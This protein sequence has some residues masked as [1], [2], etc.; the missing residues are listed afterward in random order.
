MMA[1]RPLMTLRQRRSEVEPHHD[2]PETGPGHLLEPGVSEDAPAAHVQLAPG[3]LRTWFSDHRVALNRAG[4][5]LTRELHRDR[6][7]RTADAAMPELGAGDE[8][9]R[10]TDAVVVFGLAALLPRDPGAREVGEGGPR[11]HVAPA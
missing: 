11:F 1:A 4:A 5:T 6:R 2:A 3:D 10:C 8:A 9:R 7:E